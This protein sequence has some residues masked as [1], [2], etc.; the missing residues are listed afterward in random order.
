M[1]FLDKILDSF[2][3]EKNEKLWILNKK[4]SAKT[5][6]PTKKIE[7]NQVC[8]ATFFILGHN[9]SGFENKKCEK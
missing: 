3:V 2:N 1:L 5:R 8:R 4:K 6:A 7:W 9:N